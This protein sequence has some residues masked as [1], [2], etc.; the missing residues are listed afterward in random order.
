MCSLK[1]Y[2]RLK[3]LVFGLHI[4]VASMSVAVLHIQKVRWS[5][6]CSQCPAENYNT[7]VT[8]SLQWT[9]TTRSSSTTSAITERLRPKSD[10]DCSMPDSSACACKLFVFDSRNIETNVGGTYEYFT[11][12]YLKLT[13]DAGVP[14]MIFYPMYQRLS[15]TF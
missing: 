6:C 14:Q 8:T 3:Y 4:A 13:N 12:R 2:N 1:G 7:T 10:K 11:A 5:R 15:G 9:T